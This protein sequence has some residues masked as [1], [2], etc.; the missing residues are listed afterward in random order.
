MTIKQICKN[1]ENGNIKFSEYFE[2]NLASMMK[3][4]AKKRKER[5]CLK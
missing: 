4:L 3:V 2:K 1:D 5:L